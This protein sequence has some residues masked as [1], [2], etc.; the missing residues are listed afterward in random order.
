MLDCYHNGVVTG[1]HRLGDSSIDLLE[2]ELEWSART[3]SATPRPSRPLRVENRAVVCVSLHTIDFPLER[4]RRG[5]SYRVIEL[6]TPNLL[7]RDVLKHIEDSV[8]T[9]L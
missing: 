4:S 5:L 7:L 2:Q 6:G 1:L 3:S 8:D 9:A